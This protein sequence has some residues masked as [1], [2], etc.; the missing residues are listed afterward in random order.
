MV[1]KYNSDIISGTLFLVLA[2]ILYALIPSQI[3]TME[4]TAVTAQT[5]P[6]IVTVGLFLFSCCLLLQG[7]IKTPKKTA[8]ISS[9]SFK[10]AVFRKEMRSILFASLFIVYGFLLTFTGYVISTA[11]L[12]VAILLYYGARKWYYYAISLFTIGV[13]YAVFALLLDVNLP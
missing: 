5:I 10:S 9:E 13:V 1:I 11:L 7:L 8:R 3:Q 4:T 2:G 6:R 12:S